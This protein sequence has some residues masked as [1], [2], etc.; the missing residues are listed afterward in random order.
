MDDFTL[1][2]W[3][4]ELRVFQTAVA[5]ACTSEVILVKILRGI[6]YLGYQLIQEHPSNSKDIMV[7][8]RVCF[9]L[10]EKRMGSQWLCRQLPDI[11]QHVKSI[12]PS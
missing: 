7:D 12:L 8:V 3:Q 11:S 10:V 4:K 5:N 6:I 1:D 9:D 2:Y